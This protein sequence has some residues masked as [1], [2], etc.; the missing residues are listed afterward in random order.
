MLAMPTIRMSPHGEPSDY[1]RRAAA[2]FLGTF[3][4]VFVGAG[5][6]VYARTLTDIGLAYGLIVGVMTISL[7]AISGANFN[8]AIT[9]ISNMIKGTAHGVNSVDGFIDNT[10]NNQV[11]VEPYMTANQMI[12]GS[13]V[14]SAFFFSYNDYIDEAAYAAA[15]KTAMQA[16]GLPASSTN[17]LLD[18][19]RNGWGGCG[20]GSNMSSPCRPTGPSTSTVLETFVNASRI[21]RRPAKGDWCN[22]N[23]AGLGKF[24]SANALAPYQAYVW[25]KPPGESDGSSTLIPTGPDNPD[26]KGFDRMCDPTYGGN[27]LNQNQNTNAL[28]NAPVSGRWFEAQFQQLVA[29]AFPPIP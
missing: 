3:A 25:V 22:Q 4:L 7:A 6:L 8:P 9:L 23:G 10:A 16:A 2:E 13:P 18:T 1:G 21:D 15:W 14:R 24:P 19:S 20:G 12:S 26:G 27:S 28:P 5:A 29:N 17:M 11:E